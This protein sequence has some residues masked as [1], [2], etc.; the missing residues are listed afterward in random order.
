MT[1]IVSA[2]SRSP[3]R[4]V[5]GFQILT[6]CISWPETNK[7][8]YIKLLNERNPLCELTPQASSIK[9]PFQVSQTQT[10]A[11]DSITQVHLLRGCQLPGNFKSLLGELEW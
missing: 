5:H 1:L 3:F 7:Q 6:S 10:C 4:L 9:I 8:T 2:V 11:L